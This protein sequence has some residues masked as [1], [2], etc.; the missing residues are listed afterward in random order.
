MRTSIFNRDTEPND[1][2]AIFVRRAPFVPLI[3]LRALDHS[4]NQLSAADWL[5]KMVNAPSG[6]VAVG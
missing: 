5:G 2:V 6:G 4:N 1:G 3:V